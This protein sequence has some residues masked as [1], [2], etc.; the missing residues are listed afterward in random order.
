MRTKTAKGRTTGGLFE[1]KQGENGGGGRRRR[2]PAAQRF[3]G[4]SFTERSER[5]ER[6]S[7][8]QGVLYFEVYRNLWL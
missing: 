6:E 5:V 8:Q 7:L 2:R 1:L 4:G 3:G